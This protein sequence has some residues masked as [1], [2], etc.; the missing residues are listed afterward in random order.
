MPDLELPEPIEFEW[1]EA[2]KK[3][4]WLKH[5]ISAEECEQA[6]VS[7]EVFSQPDELHSGKENRYILVSKTK[8][9]RFLFI[10]Y[11]LRKNKIRVISARSMHKK[12]KDF[13]EKE[14][15]SA[16]V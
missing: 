5:K 1:D 13:Y 8:T 3:K 15:R 11:T 4:I 7:E 10:V 12:E 9:A 16:S 2:N 6:F 14:A